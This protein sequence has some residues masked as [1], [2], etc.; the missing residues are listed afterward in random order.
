M[1]ELSDNP[2]DK[3]QAALNH[4]RPDLDDDPSADY[5]EACGE[6]FAGLSEPDKSKSIVVRISEAYGDGNEARPNGLHPTAASA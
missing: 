4:G 6:W 1:S 3:L 5:R 2:R